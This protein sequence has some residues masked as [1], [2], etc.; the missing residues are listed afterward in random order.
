MKIVTV[1]VDL[2]GVITSYALWLDGT[3][4]LNTSSSERLSVVEGLS[5]WSQHVLRLEACTAQ[6]CGKG[7]LTEVHTLEMAPEGPIL[8]ELTNHSSRSVRVRWTAPTRPN[9]NI[10][11]TLFY[12]NKDHVGDGVVDGNAVVGSW[13]TVSDLEPY[14]NYNFWIKGCNSQG[15]VQS[16]PF[17]TTTPPAAPDGLAPPQLVSATSSSLNLSW[18]APER[19]NGPGPLQYGLQ[20]RTSLQA[21][22]LKLLEN[23]SDTFSFHVDDLKPYKDYVFRITV[24]HLYGQTNGPWTTFQTAED[25][26]GT[27]NLPTVQ[28]LYPRSAVLTWATPL[29]PNGI[30]MNYTLY[31]YTSFDI[32]VHGNSTSYTFHGLLPYTNYRIQVKACTVVGCNISGISSSFRTLPAPAEGVPAPHVVSTT[33]T[34]V[35]LSWG[36]PKR[37]NGPLERWTIE[38]SIV[39]T[40]QIS[41]VVHLSPNP[42]PLSFLDSSSALSPWTRYQYRLVLQNQAGRATGPWVNMTTRPSRPA[43]L[44]PPRVSVLGP[45]LLQVSWLP[46]L[47]PNGEIHRYEIRLQD[48][49]IVHDTN[50]ASDYNITVTELIPFTHYNVSVLACSTGGGVV[51]GCTESLPTLATT[52]PTVPQGLA[53]LNIVPVTESFLAISWQPPKRPNGPNIRYT[54]LRRKTLQPL[55]LPT[56][57]TQGEAPHSSTED[58]HHW[59]HVYS[60]T[61][62]FYQDKGLSRFTQY[63]YQLWVY[64]DVG[65]SSGAI[66]TATT[67]AGIPRY[68]PSLSAFPINHT[69]IYINWTQPSLQNLQGE[70]ESYFVEVNSKGFSEMYIFPANIT[71]AVINDLWPS[72]MYSVSL[73][74]SN[75][76]HNTTKAMVNTTTEDGG[77]VCGNGDSVY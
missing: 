71:S 76:A 22:V 6:G 34:S 49:R 24:S 5:P 14:S 18:S 72:T 10:T 13:L 37:R 64:N 1:F 31:L 67:M 46:P 20:M 51:G 65:N 62:L 19:S 70:V 7:P 43:G 77:T 32:T 16:L 3:L 74:V 4:F 36:A 66:F 53:P 68:P 63:Q 11:Y 2:S 69:T 47:I 75:G 9:G 44:T 8:L 12:K 58:L 28:G 33:P 54:L 29:E 21:S 48:L 56:N 50:N 52:L 27:V 60:G 41:T 25:K 23:A 40:N 30:I 17:N 38:R 55:G 59:F 26:P 39:G 35:L 73:H 57:P 45:E 61:K 15:C 42:P